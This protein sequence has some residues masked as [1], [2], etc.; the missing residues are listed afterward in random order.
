MCTSFAQITFKWN[1]AICARARNSSGDLQRYDLLGIFTSFTTHKYRRA[2]MLFTCLTWACVR[3]ACN[4]ACT[5]R[6]VDYYCFAIAVRKHKHAKWI[7]M[8]WFSFRARASERSTKDAPAR[9]LSVYV[10]N[11]FTKAINIIEP[12][13]M[14]LF[15]HDCSRTEAFWFQLKR[16]SRRAPLGKHTNTH[17]DVLLCATLDS[18]AIEQF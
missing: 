17:R 10:C 11:W 2:T 12:L 14:Q 1:C 15:L 13:V 4:T 5:A 7:N 8:T 6:W 9:V 18:I 16:G 3:F